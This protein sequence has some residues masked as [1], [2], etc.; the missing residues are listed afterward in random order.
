MRIACAIPRF[1]DQVMTTTSDWQGATGHNWADE[2]RRTDRTFQP[3]TEALL[4]RIALMHGSRILDVGCGA[5]ELSIRVAD[6][7]P[8]AK[9]LGL[10]ISQRLVEVAT[11]RSQGENVRFQVADASGWTDPDFVPDLIVSRHGVMFFDDPQAAFA[12]LSRAA[13][14]DAHLIFTCFRDPARNGWASEVARLLADE[15]GTPPAKPDPYA[16]GPFAFADPARVESVLGE[17]WTAIDFEPY[18]FAYVAGEGE[19]PDEDALSFMTRIGPVAAA[20]RESSPQRASRL[21]E[22]LQ[23]LLDTRRRGGR[24]VFPASAWIVTAQRRL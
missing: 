19:N 15:A 5:G 11:G 10:D 7:R 9:V 14:P 21:R 3:L 23:E 4:Q 13:A 6:A 20:L 24:I 2:W 8:A 18:D 16:P 1:Y 17:G 12:H 22:R